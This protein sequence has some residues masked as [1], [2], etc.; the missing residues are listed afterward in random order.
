MSLL[1]HLE[2]TTHILSPELGY[3]RHYWAW[4]PLPSGTVG[5]FYFLIQSIL[6]VKDFYFYAFVIAR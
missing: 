2:D 1:S 4:K 3:K 5:S 6:I